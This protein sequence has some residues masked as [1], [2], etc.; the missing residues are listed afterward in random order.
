MIT[1]TF[2]IELSL[3]KKGYQFIC[4]IDE[5][6]RGCFA[7][8]LVVGAVIFPKDIKL[9]VGLADS[10]LLTAKKR[11]GL[12]EEIKKIA[13]AYVVVEISVS[14]INQVGIGQASQIA[15]RK[16]VKSLNPIP[17]FCLI[18]AFFIR[19]LDRKRQKAVPSGDKICASI[20]AASV[21]AKVYR[22]Q[23][24]E[25]LHIKYPEYNFAKN[26]GYGT[27]DHRMALRKYGL[28]KVHRTSFN[29][30]KFL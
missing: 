6:G 3:F 13:R 14:V 16:V 26:K 23:L 28:S 12:T 19:H 17:D 30:S 18:D 15:F 10:K 24:M 5:V 7:G 4:G 2:D 25:K 29:L 1:P 11:S 8:P 27:L 22:D 9:P 20:S 21:I